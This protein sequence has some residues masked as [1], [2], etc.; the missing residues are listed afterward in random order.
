MEEWKD[1]PG[2]LYL[3]QYEVSNFGRVKWKKPPRILRG[4]ERKGY[5]TVGLTKDGQ[6]YHK[7]D[8]FVHRLVAFA[9][10][11]NPLSLP[12]VDHIDRNPSNNQLANL[13][14]AS[15]QDQVRNSAVMEGIAHPK[16]R[17]SILQCSL[18]GCFLKKWD[19]I[20]EANEA[21]KQHSG[22]ENSN[23][24]HIINAIK[25]KAIYFFSTWKY[26]E[27]E[28]EGET[29]VDAKLPSII[30]SENE[31]KNEANANINI[32]LLPGELENETET[33]LSPS[34]TSNT[35]EQK[36]VSDDTQDETRPGDILKVTRTGKIMFPNGR[37]TRGSADTR[38]YL[39][40]R[41]QY[42]KYFVHRI[43]LTTFEGAS[44]DPEKN[45]VNHKD[46]NKQNNALENLEWATATEQ[47]S[48]SWGMSRKAGQTRG[49]YKIAQYTL[50]GKHMETFDSVL[51]ACSKR[52]LKRGTIY[53]CINNDHRKRIKNSGG[54]FLWREVDASKEA[55]LTIALPS[56]PRYICPEALYEYSKSTHELVK[57]YS[58]LTAATRSEELAR[59]KKGKK[60]DY[61]TMKNYVAGT[62]I[63]PGN[64]YFTEAPREKTEAIEINST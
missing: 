51:H 29:F 42:Q 22:F 6:S 55:P 23:T 39:C 54:G 57:K 9:F 52:N 33:S 41:F 62:S 4:H 17:R 45:Q 14:W 60:T 58:S 59:V 19:S 21:I 44:P 63:P 47:V 5:V 18:E 40:V 46:G 10:L 1:L 34:D 32:L 12:T 25:A 24:R 2:W 26:D 28:K 13:R 38:G 16:L 31:N 53:N 30:K 37:I 48:H 7:N 35:D 50:E 3:S 20:T 27:S 56:N 15:S 64:S 36:F 43:I 61:H 11:P 49:R 8:Y